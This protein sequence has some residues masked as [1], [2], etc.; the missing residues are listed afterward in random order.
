M[1]WADVIGAA[2]VVIAVAALAVAGWSL[3]ASQAS[4]RAAQGDVVG[5]LMGDYAEPAMGAALRLI[6][7]HEGILAETTPHDTP[8]RH[9]VGDE[10]REVPELLDAGRRLHLFV[11][12]AAILLA[13]G[14][15]SAGLFRD[16]I[17][18]TAG[19][20]LWAEVWLPYMRVKP[21]VSEDAGNLGWADNLLSEHPPRA[22][23]RLETEIRGKPYRPFF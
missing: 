6:Q 19:Y 4:K 11:R 9:V 13:N 3:A 7:R 15:I 14:I 8:L 22:A 10:A 2:Q 5:R 1:N 12:Q 18:G 20:R 23:G 17:V 21:N 16:A